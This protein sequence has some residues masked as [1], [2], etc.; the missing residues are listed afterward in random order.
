MKLSTI[1]GYLLWGVF[2]NALVRWIIA[3]LIQDLAIFGVLIVALIVSLWM[4][5]ILPTIRRRW[6]SYTLFSLI[7]GQGLSIIATASMLKAVGLGAI[8]IV[9]LF[10]IALWFGKVRFL[11][12]FVG[13]MG[14]VLATIWLPFTEWPFLT[15]FKVDHY[16]KMHIQ[17]HDMPEDPFAVIH[18]QTGDAVITVDGYTPTKA[19]LQQ[20]VQH[21][22]NS[23]SAL[24]D[25]LQTAQEQYQL[26]IIKAVNGRVVTTTPTPKELAQVDPLQLVDAF[27]PFE[28]ANWYIVNGH[29]KEYLTPFMQSHDAVA[30]SLNTANYSASIRKLTN[31]AVNYE[32]K[33]WD[34][35]LQQLGVTPQHSGWF[36]QSGQLTG[37]FQGKTVSVPVSATNVA[38]LG[39]FTSNTD[40]QLLL[41][42]DNQLQ[43]FDLATDKVVS[44]HNGTSKQPIPNDIVIGK[45]TQSGPDAIYVNASPAYVLEAGSGGSWKTM[46]TASSASFR[47]ETVRNQAGKVPEIVTNDPSKVRNAPTRYFSAYRFVPGAGS[48]QGKLEREWRVFRT[49]V[50]NVTPIRMLS[51]GTEQLAVAIYG[52]GEYLI[53]QRTHIPVVVV[54]YV[55]L[56]VVI[57]AGWF[58]RIRRR[59]EGRL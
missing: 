42:G 47:F 33:N 50:V 18:M 20:L 54:S 40:Q 36:I 7:L 21:A 10:I 14:L 12:L 45:L 34:R 22:T 53:L 25:V 11:P 26:V 32:L 28:V 49:N 44:T 23:P 24:Q 29:V 59:K 15:Q 37:T 46:Y 43:V 57:C 56:A 9:G 41:V 51:N 30:L 48:Q 38:G 19:I 58:L 39:H 17:I 13:T 55:L 5:S 35:M 2:A 3:P 1:I 16:G 6:I 27:V 4:S 31:Q 52:T 8:I